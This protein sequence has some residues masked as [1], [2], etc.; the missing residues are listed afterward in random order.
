MDSIWRMRSRVPPNCSAVSARV[1]LSPKRILPDHALFE[2]SVEQLQKVSLRRGAFPRIIMSPV[3]H[4]APPL[5]LILIDYIPFFR[6]R[7]GVFG[8]IFKNFFRFDFL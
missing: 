4:N 1:F 6:F 7:Q 3:F 5:C 8:E 2:A